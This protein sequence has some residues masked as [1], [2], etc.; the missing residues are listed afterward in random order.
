MVQLVECRADNVK[1][2]SS[3]IS[4]MFSFFFSQR[5][6]KDKGKREGWEDT[7]RG[8]N[9]EKNMPKCRIEPVDAQNNYCSHS[10]LTD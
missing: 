5:G 9:T 10:D 3:A 6:K 2:S 1:V 7:R 4:L 8:K